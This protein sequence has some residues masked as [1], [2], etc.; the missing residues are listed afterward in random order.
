MKW[1]KIPAQEVATW[2]QKLQQTEAYFFQFPY[3]MDGYHDFRFCSPAYYQCEDNQQSVAYVAMLVVKLLGFKVGLVFRG[4]VVLDAGRP[5]ALIIESWAQ[6]CKNDGFILLKISPPNSEMSRVLAGRADVRQKDYFPFYSGSQVN[7]LI[8]SRRGT[9]DE[10]LQSYKNIA[11]RKIKQADKVGYEI[12]ESTSEEDL[13]QAYKIFTIVGKRKS[14]AYRSVES[15]LRILRT[16]AEF[17]LCSLYIARS[18]GQII[19]AVFVVKDGHR[20]T[21]HSSALDTADMPEEVS[22]SC[23]LHFE[24]MKRELLERGRDHYNI[25]YSEGK[26][27]EFKDQFNPEK[28]DYPAAV[29][30]VLAPVRFYFYALVIRVFNINKLKRVLRKW[31]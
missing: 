4:P 23:R 20:A 12:I 5:L 10:L 24:A 19:N 14:F 9:A 18:K 16:G 13:R 17:G 30:L 31:V 15:Y 22:P 11:R 21:H 28:V 26:V 27:R 1:R 6:A 7:D 29:T 8:I 25:S 3:Y 2:N